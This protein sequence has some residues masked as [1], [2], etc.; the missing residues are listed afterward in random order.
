M[1]TDRTRQSLV[2]QRLGRRKVEARFD[3]G[4]VSS[5]GGSLLLGELDRRTGLLE[6]F[7]R[8]F[9]DHRRPELI[10]HPVLDLLRQ[11]VYGLCLGY[12]DLNDHD[13]LRGDALL[14]AATGKRDPCGESRRRKR[15]KGYALAGKSTLNRL[16]LTPRTATQEA[17][18]KKVVAD[19]ER[20]ERFFV[21]EFFDA[22]KDQRVERLVL[23]IDPS[24]IKLHG[25]Q[26][27]KYYNGYYGHY[28]YFPLYIFCGQSLLVA[29]LRR[30]SEDGCAGTVDALAWLVPQL[31]RQWPHVEI[32]VR[33]DAGF[34]REEIFAWCEAN[35]VEYVV[36]LARNSRLVECIASEMAEAQ[37]G[38]EATGE[39]TRVFADLQYRTQKSW[40]RQRRVVAK[41]E[42]LPGKDNPRFVVT[43]H[44]ADRFDART[45]YEDE[46]CARGEMENRIKEEQLDLFGYRTS[47]NPMVANQLRVWLSAVAHMLIVEF[48]RTAL[49]GTDLERAQGKTIRVR[50][51]KVGAIVKVSVRRVRVALSS[52]FPLHE[53]FT[54]ALRNIQQ[55][56]EPQ[57]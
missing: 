26:E 27:G 49:A 1:Q 8:C 28:C 25:D 36:G 5:D 47:C 56:Y 52:V 21:E 14:A 7:A 39:P 46:Y 9:V 20:V 6:R 41:A 23:D 24:D 44:D 15:D 50:L 10:E 30:S 2:F 48:R 18:Y 34:G 16:E 51:L 35:Q 17:R 40:S 32:E 13:T 4:R 19:P 42:V 38:H 31:R 55:T 3:G 54:A 53:V 45:L 12:E 37:E 57:G 11:R 22:N 33:A 43:S 29:N